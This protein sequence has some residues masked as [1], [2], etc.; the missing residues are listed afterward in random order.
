VT[1]WK[2]DP[3]C[4]NV[5]AH[6]LRRIA[7]A[8]LLLA[9]L[10]LQAQWFDLRTPGVPRLEDGQPDLF[11]PT[12]RT[13]DGRPDLSGIW[14]PVATS[15][16]LFD[17]AKI[18]DWAVDVMA[19]HEKSFF[20][21]DPRFHCLPSGPGAYPA[22]PANGGQRRIVQQPTFIAI[23]NPDMT[24]RQVFVDGR[25]LEPEPLVSTW[26]GYSVGRW[27]GDTLVIESNGFNDK[28]WLT[29]EGLPHS[30][31][32]RITERYRRLDYG[33]MSLE[34]TYDDPGTFKETVEASIDL[35]NTPDAGT[36]EIVCNES[37]TGRSHYGGEISDAD[38]NGVTVPVTTLEK[39]VGIY[40]GMWLQFFVKAEFVLENGE[41]A[42]IRTPRYP[43][44]SG[45]EESAR[46]ELIARSETAFDCSC[47]IGFVFELDERGEAIEVGE[48]HVSGSW[49]FERVR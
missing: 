48:V 11:A 37:E 24:Y 36:G 49:P 10:P 47:G 38:I 8:I 18:Q 43:S 46:Y 28:T 32:L 44:T 29:R 35:V 17:R 5:K 7:I 6:M 34:V 9:A 4:L 27:E 19:T 42:L 30:D 2:L 39:Y 33:H 45:D 14:Q 22:D 20:A 3:G 31:Q 23:L 1:D 40:E 41:F 25:E 26:L 21:D 15:G 13:T 12:P 16:S